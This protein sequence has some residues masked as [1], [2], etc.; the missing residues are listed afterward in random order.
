MDICAKRVLHMEIGQ[1]SSIA[2]PTKRDEAK[3][4]ASGERVRLAATEQL[5]GGRPSNLSKHHLGHQAVARRLRSSR[6][7]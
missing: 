2:A 5:V 3:G 6:G 7:R 4:E 1:A